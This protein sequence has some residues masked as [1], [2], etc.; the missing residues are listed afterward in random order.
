M[1]PDIDRFLRDLTALRQFGGDTQTKGVRRPAFTDTDLE[2]R[3]WLGQ[4]FEA[5]GL[6]VRMDPVGNLFG[7]APGD[8]R[9]F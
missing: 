9:A 8:G 3:D 1:K 6:E 4:R 2:A 7:L 5:A